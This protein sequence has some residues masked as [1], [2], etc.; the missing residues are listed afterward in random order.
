MDGDIQRAF[1]AYFHLVDNGARRAVTLRFTER[2]GKGFLRVS[3]VFFELRCQGFVQQ[4]VAFGLIVTLD[5]AGL[6]QLQVGQRSL[7]DD[8]TLALRGGTAYRLLVRGAGDLALRHPRDEQRAQR[9]LRV[10][11]QRQTETEEVFR[12]V[13]GQSALKLFPKQRPRLRE[14]VDDLA[15]FGVILNGIAL[16]PFVIAAYFLYH[17]VRRAGDDER[18]H[19]VVQV[20]VCADLAKSPALAKIRRHSAVDCR[21]FLFPLFRGGKFQIVVQIIQQ[22]DGHG[23]GVLQ[24]AFSEILALIFAY[25]L[26]QKLCALFIIAHIAVH[27]YDEVIT[28]FARQ[29]LQGQAVALVA[30]LL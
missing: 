1:L 24:I 20:A 4:S 14:A 16:A 25:R 5:T 21:D 12:R 18:I 2:L 13:I 26:F 11:V 6:I 30:V 22:K 29:V 7:G 9:H 23:F 17:A 19:R 28:P 10:A 27:P 8:K 15:G 3:D